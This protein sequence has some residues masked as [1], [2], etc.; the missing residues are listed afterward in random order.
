MKC[1]ISNYR[2]YF[3]IILL[4]SL[5][6]LCYSEPF[7]YLIAIHEGRMS[8][9]YQTS[10]SYNSNKVLRQTT[11]VTCGPTALATLLNYYFY[12]NTSEIEMAELSDTF[13]NQT[14]T[15]AG[16]RNAA[17]IKGYEA[18]GYQMTLSQLKKQIETSNIPVLIHY[19]EPTLHYA[20]VTGI[21]DNYVLTSDPSVGNV[22]LD[23]IDFNRRWSGKALVIKPG[24]HKVNTT[25]VPEEKKSAELRIDSL[26]CATKMM[27]RFR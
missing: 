14:T 11:E 25:S 24:D 19:K 23:L 17:R 10:F 16:L 12:E 1:R 13:I 6:Q 27:M 2:I 22:T 9:E 21:I 3:F 26:N 15:L 5:L 18:A 8:L 20:L 4:T 7:F